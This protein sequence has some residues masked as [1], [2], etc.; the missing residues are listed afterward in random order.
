MDTSQRSIALQSN[1]I[2]PDRDELCSRLLAEYHSAW[3][4][5]ISGDPAANQTLRLI[6]ADILRWGDDRTAGLMAILERL[7]RAPMHYLSWYA[8]KPTELRAWSIGVGPGDIYVYPTFA[9]PLSSPGV[10]RSITDLLYLANPFLM[11]LMFV[12][13][14]TGLLTAERREPALVL[15]ISLVAYVTCV[16]TVLQ[17]DQDMQCHIAALSGWPS[18]SPSVNRDGFGTYAGDRNGR[19]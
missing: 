5:N 8:S 10:V 9:S 19:P 1:V 12:G 4:V 14:V 18:A 13:V 16:F 2:R 11:L 7:G 6:D 17:A 15:A 3:I